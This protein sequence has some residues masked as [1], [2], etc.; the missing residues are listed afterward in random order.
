MGRAVPNHVPP[1]RGGARLREGQVRK[2]EGTPA[3]QGLNQ[4]VV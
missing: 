3:P 1:L 2:Q 4:L